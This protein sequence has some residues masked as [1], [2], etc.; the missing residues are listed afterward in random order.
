MQT[1]LWHLTTHMTWKVVDLLFGNVMKINFFFS[2]CLQSNQK[3][4]YRNVCVKVLSEYEHVVFCVYLG[5]S[6][7][8]GS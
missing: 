8:E 5:L 2:D 7:L 1:I 3:L 6:L 4:F